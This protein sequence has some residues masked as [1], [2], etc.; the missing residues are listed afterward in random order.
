M[1][2]I[3]DSTVHDAAEKV[4]ELIRSLDGSLLNADD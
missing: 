1:R 3:D 4:R 2:S